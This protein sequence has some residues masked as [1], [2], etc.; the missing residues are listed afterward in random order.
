METFNQTLQIP[1]NRQITLTLPDSIPTGE[2]EMVLVIHPKSST[3]VRKEDEL[4]KLVGIL[5]DSP[6]FEGDPVQIQ[7]RMR[8]EWDE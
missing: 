2:A 7:R 3:A 6:N 8:D 1:D 5:K 4:L